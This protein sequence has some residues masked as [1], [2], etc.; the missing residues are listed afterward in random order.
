[1]RLIIFIGC[2]GK[3]ALRCVMA[4]AIVNYYIVYLH[5]SQF[6]IMLVHKFSCVHQALKRQMVLLI[7]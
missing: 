4:L 5:L 1:M 2:R 6:D 7:I 3:A